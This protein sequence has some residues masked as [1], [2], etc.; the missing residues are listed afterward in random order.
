MMNTLSPLEKGHLPSLNAD[1]VPYHLPTPTRL[2][3]NVR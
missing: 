3:E 2:S 1:T